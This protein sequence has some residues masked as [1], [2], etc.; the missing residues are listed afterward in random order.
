MS[1]KQCIHC[2]STEGRTD[3]RSYGPTLHATKPNEVINFDYL[4]MPEDEDTLSKYVLVLKDDFSGFVE[5]IPCEVADSMTCARA[6]VQWFQRFGVVTTRVSD[7]GTHFKNAVIEEFHHFVTAYCP[8]ANVT[9]AVVN[10][11]YSKFLIALLSERKL[12]LAKWE[13]VLSVVA[14]ALN[15][16]PADRIGNR[17]PVAA[18]TVLPTPMPFSAMFTQQGLVKQITAAELPTL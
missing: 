6:L 13:S 10:K 3:L 11:L 5:L 9:V 2:W 17:A 1:V 12:L 18:F 15:H 8:W 16:Q 4:S 7:Q 14:T